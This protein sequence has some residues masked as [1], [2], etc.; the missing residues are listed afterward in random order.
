MTTF[1]GQMQQGAAPPGA[2]WVVCDGRVFHPRLA[3]DQKLPFD[4]PVQC[5]DYVIN[6]G[7]WGGGIGIGRWLA[8]VPRSSTTGANTWWVA[9][10]NNAGEATLPAN[11]PTVMHPPAGVALA[12]A[13]PPQAHAPKPAKEQKK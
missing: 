12:A 6:T 2:Y 10:A 11:T 5:L 8:R 1:A 9:L 4:M 7:R 3:P 13:P